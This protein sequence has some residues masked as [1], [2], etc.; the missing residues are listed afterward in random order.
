MSGTGVRLAYVRILDLRLYSCSVHRRVLRQALQHQ[1][2]CLWHI[3][4]P[5]CAY[6]LRMP[7]RI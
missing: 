6:V 5:A 3:R 2:C 7:V 1:S 4:L